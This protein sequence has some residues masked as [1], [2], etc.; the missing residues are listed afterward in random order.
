MNAITFCS[1]NLSVKDIALKIQMRPLSGWLRK[2]GSLGCANQELFMVH[3]HSSFEHW[4]NTTLQDK[5]KLPPA[6]KAKAK[7]NIRESLSSWGY[8]LWGQ[9][10]YRIHNIPPLLYYPWKN[11]PATP[12]F[13][14]ATFFLLFYFNVNW[15][16]FILFFI[17]LNYM[18]VYVI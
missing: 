6:G 2:L 18:Y 8:I 1:H 10:M 7:G 3:Q 5:W 17:L 9:W 11:Y 4:Y 13:S 12:S 16:N 15:V 14:K